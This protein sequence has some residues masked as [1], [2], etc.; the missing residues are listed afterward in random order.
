MTPYAG[1][2]LGRPEGRQVAHQAELFGQEK[3]DPRGALTYSIAPET[4]AVAT[5]LVSDP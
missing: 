5:R 4:N 1:D 2:V 3:P